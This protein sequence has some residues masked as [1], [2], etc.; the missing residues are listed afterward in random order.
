MK[1]FANKLCLLTRIGQS[2]PEPPYSSPLYNH[3]LDSG[4]SHPILDV[5]KSF[6]DVHFIPQVYIYINQWSWWCKT[7]NILS[8]IV[9]ICRTGQ[10]N[11]HILI[12]DEHNVPTFLGIWAV[13]RVKCDVSV[14]DVFHLVMKA[15]TFCTGCPVLIKNGSKLRRKRSTQGLL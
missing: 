2:V 12:Y 1:S 7:F 13:L 15:F 10:A 5:N 6:K 9:S 11:D 8:S 3:V 14:V 4:E